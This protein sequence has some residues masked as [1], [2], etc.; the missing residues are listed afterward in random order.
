MANT[1]I[2][3]HQ[4]VFANHKTLIMAAA[5]STAYSVKHEARPR[6]NGRCRWSVWIEGSKEALDKIKQV[7]YLLD[8]S[9]AE[10]LRTVTNRETQFRLSEESWTGFTL[11][12]QIETEGG[13]ITELE[14]ELTF[15]RKAA[16][17]NDARRYKSNV[18]GSIK[19]NGVRQS[20]ADAT[21]AQDAALELRASYWLDGAA[22]GGGESHVV[23]LRDD[24]VLEL[25]FDDGTTWFCTT[26][27]L[28]NVFP[29]AAQKKRSA[30]G[31]FEIPQTLR[32]AGTERGMVTD[33][34]VKMVNVFGKKAAAKSVAYFAADLERKQLDNLSGLY[35]LDK[36]FSFK[37]FE[38]AVSEK[39]CLVF[40]HGT[41]SSTRGSFG[42]LV[43]AGVWDYLHTAYPGNVL[44]FQHETLTKSPLENAVDLVRCLP[45][46]AVLH[47]VTHSRGGLV[48]D[49]L[50]RFCNS[51]ENRRGFDPN[52][53]EYLKKTARAGDLRNIELLQEE[54]RSRK[55]SIGKFVR[56]ACPAAGTI[57]ASR[58][59]DNFFNITA[60]LIGLGT[61]AGLNPLYGAFKNLIAAAM[62]TKNDVDVLPGIEAMNPDSPFIKVLNSPGSSVIIDSPLVVIAGNCKVRPDLRALLII[63]SKLF[64]F[65]DNDLVVNTRSMYQGAKR[66]KPV[67]YL[68]DES[69]GVDH[70]HYFK[71]R[72]TAAALREA[73]QATDEAALPDFK[74]NEQAVLLEAQR[75]AMLN[76]EGGQ[77]FANTVTGQKPIAVLLPGIMGS[78]LSVKGDLLWINYLRFLGGGLKNLNI[79]AEGVEPV[80]LIKTS[81]GKLVKYLSPTY[82]VVTFPYDWRLPLAESAAAFNS[83]IKRLLQY[84]LPV[85]IIG[86][87]MGGVLVRDFI[88]NHPATWAELNLLDGFRLL[89]LG[90]PL[91]GSFRIPAVLFGQ[92]SLIN[93]LSKV[94]IF[95]T[96]KELLEMFS[97]LPGILN[98]LP[99]ATDDDNNFA[100][101]EVWSRMGA[102]LGNWPLPAEKDLADF[103]N[104][105][106]H[107]LQRLSEIDYT[108]VAYIAGKDKA[109]PCGYR[110]DDT[111]AGKELVFLSTAEGDKS[112][113]WESGIPQKLIESKAVYYVNVTHGSLANE[114]SIFDG[115][116]E[117]LHTGFTNQFSKTRPVVR[118]E[119]KVFRMPVPHEFDL[120]ADG[121]E[122]SLLGLEPGEKK[123]EKA[124][125]DSP[126]LVSVRNGDLRYASFPVLVGHFLGDGILYAEK[127]LDENLNKALSMQHRLG[128]Y[129]GPIGTNTV[130]LPGEGRLKGAVVVGLDNFGSLTSFQLIQTI[131]QGV[132]KYLLEVNSRAA[133]KTDSLPD[134]TGLS[135]VLVGSGYGGLSI[136]NS[137]QAVVQ[138]VRNANQKI[139]GVNAGRM[140]R[141]ERIEFIELY[142]DRAL[143]CFYALSKMEKNGNGP[144][145]IATDKSGIKTLFGAQKR[146]PAE[147]S[148]GWWQRISVR[149]N[150]EDY[151]EGKKGPKDEYDNRVRC[152]GFS[153]STG[154]AREEKRNVYISPAGL[155]AMLNESADK[156][157]WSPELAKTLFELLVPLD[158]KEQLKKQCNI[159]WI[160]DTFTAAYPWELLQD[161]VADARPLSIN[162]GMIRQLATEQYRLRINAVTADRAL[163]IADPD[164]QGFVTQLPGAEEEGKLVDALLEQN[165]FDRQTIVRGSSAQILKALYSSDYKII[166]LAGH[167]LFD[168]KKPGNSGMVIG[169]KEFLSTFHIYQMSTV[170]ELVFVN[171]CY[172]GKVQG[173]AEELYSNR[174]KLAANIGTQLI[175]NGVKAV[176]AAGWE[177]S[178]AA[179]LEFTRLF[180]QHMFDGYNFGTA[181]QEARKA[182][183]EAYGDATNTWG[184]YQ[185]YGDPFYKFREAAAQKKEYRPAFVIA[186]EAEIELHN[187]RSDLKTP[188][189]TLQEQRERL[190]AISKAVDK[191]GLRRAVITELE[192]LV[193]ADMYDY[194]RAIGKLESLLALERADFSIATLEKYCNLRMKKY[195]Y[196]FLHHHRRPGDIVAKMDNVI[197]DLNAL[198]ALRNT[199]ERGSLL[200]SAY[201]RKGLLVSNPKQK[202]K[203]Y[204]EAAYH[205][206]RANFIKGSVYALTNWYE[207]ESILMLADNRKW[208]GTVSGGAGTYALPSKEEAVKT[209]THLPESF[210]AAGRDMDY[211][212][213]IMVPNV[214]LCLLVMEAS[215][216]QDEKDWSNLLEKYREVWNTAG[217]RGDKFIEIEHLAILLDALSLT[218]KPAARTL[219]KGLQLVKK[220]LERMV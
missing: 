42:E 203:A 55:I 60:N 218:E 172:L 168:E 94:D 190:E 173:L 208:K 74:A 102:P 47:L 3:S 196:D 79:K 215:A 107:V 141:I 37:P 129:P 131:E 132:A 48:G 103:N 34:A 201:K 69:E 46:S 183:Y 14:H 174:F 189:Y 112:V 136:E 21:E 85:K 62:D 114:P 101:K 165:N 220:G 126:L 156:N 108:N 91:G 122:R 30:D 17:V 179:A 186:E 166:H 99:Y 70:F 207:L 4:N 25:V 98:L 57:L 140:R 19:I 92:D 147:V 204:A 90:A 138:G 28:D 150:D 133:F 170:P 199:A 169:K 176:V 149:L 188:R 158:F 41:N 45:S 211:W 164:L 58:R 146:I 160:V 100:R 22:R 127:Q 209:L 143:S 97:K 180:Y 161:K 38:P 75:N 8:P 52:E 9:F 50:A 72:R 145:K 67:Q 88:I 144:L 159:N 206:M 86:H 56:V 16:P 95:H 35:R 121:I 135:A 39:P 197:T 116:A 217:T 134:A 18:P 64:Y 78:N 178:D 33:V 24:D 124:A 20:V 27:S 81:Y 51:N 54:F 191:A 63:T 157:G 125:A 23:S 44:A 84:K 154:G 181:V 155:D 109:T 82:D 198:S 142:E 53:T 128:L 171:C 89:F 87:S 106:N 12:V 77:V 210:Q 192:A 153:V 130:I 104:Y 184:A 7:A 11:R 167:G 163:V 65:T 214:T 195:A 194:D 68:F 36:A 177:V 118:S 213:L 80:S 202:E 49:V 182:I 15:D 71:N 26:E 193:Y 31:S 117:I 216:G 115:M 73:L 185:A 175:Q 40:I 61:G 2:C 32:G 219:R 152:L 43:S 6:D 200:G 13:K 212:A 110:I 123:A 1:R 66:E 151:E 137:V 119:E 113:T 187:L 59:L 111:N 205:Y 5:K 105:R 96:K 148:E 120:S 83:Q 139:D 162:G 93:S 29:E 10:S 76:A